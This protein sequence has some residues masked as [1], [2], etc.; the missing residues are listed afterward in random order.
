MRTMSVTWAARRR[1]RAHAPHAGRPCRGREI[2]TATSRFG[3]RCE[4]A[5]GGGGL[6]SVRCDRTAPGDR[7]EPGRRVDGRHRSIGGLPRPHERCCTASSERIRR[8][9][10]GANHVDQRPYSRNTH[11]PR[12]TLA[13]ERNPSV[14]GFT[15]VPVGRV[16]IF[17]WGLRRFRSPLTCPGVRRQPYSGNGVRR[18][19]ETAGT[20]R[21][22]ERT[23]A[24]AFFSK[25]QT[26]AALD[27]RHYAAGSRPGRE[28]LA[29]SIPTTTSSRRLPQSRT[30][31]GEPN[32]SD[33]GHAGRRAGLLAGWCPHGRGDT[34]P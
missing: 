20:C 21:P 8:P 30:R 22:R 14:V 13:G 32:E 5:H 4:W 33:A 15:V 29:E 27:R 26:S 25:L 23:V 19:G 28:H 6:R 16:T 11:G 1:S 24:T 17:R 18:Y 12:R 3:R 7:R 10:S 34:R 2:R 31:T 9:S